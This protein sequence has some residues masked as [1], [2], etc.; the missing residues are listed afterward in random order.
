MARSI[1]K[2]ALDNETENAIYI[3]DALNGRFCNCYCAECH[4]KMVAVQGKS[5]NHY[6]WHF[7]HF[8]N[9]PNCG[10]GIETAIHK[11]AKK[12]IADNTKIL[13]PGETLLYSNPRQE[14]RFENIIPDISVSSNEVDIHFEIRVTHK[15]GQSKEEFYKKG[16]HKS[17][18]ID[19]RGFLY[20]IEPSELKKIVLN[21]VDIKRKIFWMPKSGDLESSTTDNESWNWLIGI[22]IFI[23]GIL[24]LPRRGAK[25]KRR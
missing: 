4:T 3:D 16:E 1:I 9:D 2:Y 19:L 7:R 17:I 22:G 13:I 10:G 11:L 20:N 8:N 23:V 15:V 21:R 5:A 24:V 18:E 14:N 6:E 25:K 12:I